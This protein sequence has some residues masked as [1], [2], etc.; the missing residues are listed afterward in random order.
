MSGKTLC[1]NSVIDKLSIPTR[2]GGPGL[3]M[4]SSNVGA[5]GERMGFGTWL[6]KRR[7]R[8]KVNKTAK[9]G[10]KRLNKILK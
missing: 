8:K 9:S 7:I 2:A 3:A 10:V 5:E 6:L 1:A 4:P